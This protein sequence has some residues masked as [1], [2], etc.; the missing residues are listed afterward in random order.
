MK[1]NPYSIITRELVAALGKLKPAEQREYMRVALDYVQREAG[2]DAD[3]I[4][5][6]IT[7]EPSPALT[8]ERR[9]QLLATIAR[10]FKSQD[11]SL[12]SLPTP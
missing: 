11:L 10:A 8:Q 7:G 4:H 6:L 2:A 1:P 9:T 3:S 12:L 5:S